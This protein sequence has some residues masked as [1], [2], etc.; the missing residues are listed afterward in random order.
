LFTGATALA[1]QAYRPEERDQA[2]G[3][4]NFFMFVTLA[5]SSFGSGVLVTTQGWTLLNYGSLVPVGVSGAAILW[6]AL[7]QRKLKAT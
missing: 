6:L 1:L 4:L 7:H 2:Q 5:M 3:A